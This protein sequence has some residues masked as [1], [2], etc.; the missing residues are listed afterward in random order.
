MH[1]LQQQQP[2]G[3]LNRVVPVVVMYS[4]LHSLLLQGQCI[5]PA[6]LEHQGLI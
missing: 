4:L 3:N 1:A 2:S 5:D 6:R